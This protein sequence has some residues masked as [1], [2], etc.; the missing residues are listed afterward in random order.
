[1]PVGTLATVK[2]LTNRDLE[3]MQAEII[4]GNAY[5]L[6]LRPG[7]ELVDEMGGLHGFMNWKKS[8]LTDSGG[9]Q[10]MSLSNLRKIKEDGVEFSSHIDGSRHS[11]SPEKSMEIQRALGSDIVMAFDECLKYGATHKETLDSMNMTTRWARRCQSVELKEHQRLFGILQGG[12]FEDLRRQHVEDLEALDFFGFAIGGLSVGEPPE[13]MVRILDALQGYMPETKPRYL[14]GVGRPEDLIESVYRGVDMFDCVMP[15]RNARNGH[16]FT[17][18]GVIKIRNAKYKNDQRPLDETCNCYTCQNHSRAYLRH[19][20]ISGEILASQLSTVH[21]IY[22]YLDLMRQVRK[23]IKE[24]RFDDFR[25]AFYKDLNR[26]KE[27]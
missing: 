4:L 11:I 13:E 24:K 20:H 7:H 22:Y 10:V 17:K 26:N 15:T 3:D 2:A 16:L 12:M 27:N 19:L 8:I 25:Q 14:M 21:N 1:M 6:Y 23:A 5:H 18:T 9:F